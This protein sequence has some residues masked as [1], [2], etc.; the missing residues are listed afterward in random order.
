[1]KRLI[2]V[3]NPNSSRFKDVES[4][5]LSAAR[6]LKGYTVGKYEVK[7]T[8]IED[9]AKCLAKILEDGD[10]VVSAGGDATGIIAVHGVMQ[11]GKDARLAVL[12]YGNF[13]DLARTLGTS[14]FE[15]IFKGKTKKL[16]PLD[17]IVDGKHFRY[18]TCYVTMGMTGEA[19]ELFDGAKVRKKLQKG[20][21][22]SWRSYI[23]LMKWY[24][25]NRHKKLFIPE[26]KLNGELK[27][28]K[29]SDY[30]ALNGLSMCRVM[31]GGDWYLDKSEFLHMTGKLA[32]LWNLSVLMIRSIFKQVPGEMTKGDVI[33]FTKLATVELQAEGEYKVF[34]GI[35][36]IEIKKSE[37]ALKIVS[38]R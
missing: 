13:N 17:I 32:N 24:F 10:L 21:K 34:S 7:R 19:V 2:I 28:I 38:L 31:K 35:K 14:K 33:E 20:H 8:N 6:E 23:D 18:A 30:C 11:S 3:Y 12:P 4:E 25:K 26:F 36:K 27:H 16:Y 15:D 1:M 5:V 37:Q 29:T 22:S 9:N